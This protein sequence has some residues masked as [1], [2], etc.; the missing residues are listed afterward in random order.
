MASAAASA[1]SP[2]GAHEP[3]ELLGVI[4]SR[5]VA[6]FEPEARLRRLACR[7]DIAADVFTAAFRPAGIDVAI[8]GGLIAAAATLAASPNASL[9]VNAARRAEFIRI[10][11]V[12][13]PIVPDT[14]LEGRFFDSG[15]LTRPGGTPA[16]L[17][18]TTWARCAAWHRGHASYEVEGRE[19]RLIMTL[20]P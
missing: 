18:A 14:T 7:Q 19:G 12:H 3:E 5:A 10:A 1:D 11:I 2:A 16:C 17:G 8:F 15:W 20:M 13:A 9:S 4:M 6:E